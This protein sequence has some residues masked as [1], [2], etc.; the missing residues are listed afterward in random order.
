MED[1][2]RWLENNRLVRVMLRLQD[3]G[4]LYLPSDMVRLNECFR[5]PLFSPTG[6]VECALRVVLTIAKYPNFQRRISLL[7]PKNEFFEQMAEGPSKDEKKECKDEYFV[8]WAMR[9][10]AIRRLRKKFRARKTTD[11]KRFKKMFDLVVEACM[12]INLKGL[13]EGDCIE[14]LSF[15]KNTIMPVLVPFLANNYFLKQVMRSAFDEIIPWDRISSS[16]PLAAYCFLLPDQACH[17]PEWCFASTRS[18][19][20]E[21]EIGCKIQ[22][23]SLFACSLNDLISIDGDWYLRD[24]VLD[25]LRRITCAYEVKRNFKPS[26]KKYA[27]WVR[28]IIALN[29]S[30]SHEQITLMSMS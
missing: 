18:M 24:E 10:D 25:T 6:A 26:M 8:K 23:F 22:Y 1:R 21:K 5:R 15:L 30:L 2:A 17:T 4:L 7:Y 28:Q 16:L 3:F 9:E 20:G 13:M 11:A 14:L 12:D 29:R 27:N 19:Y